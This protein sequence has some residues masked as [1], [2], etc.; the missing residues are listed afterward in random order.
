MLLLG[1]FF[2]LLGLFLLIAALFGAS[3]KKK[4]SFGGIIVLGPIVLPLGSL[5][6]YW[7]AFLVASIVLAVIYLALLLRGHL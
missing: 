7:P 4:F 5:K 6:K 1:L 2:V 3:G